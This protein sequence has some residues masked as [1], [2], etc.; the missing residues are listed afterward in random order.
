MRKPLGS[1]AWAIMA[2]LLILHN[3]FWLW[4]ESGRLLGMPVG[5]TY[6]VLYCLVTLMALAFL[7]RVAWPEPRQL[8]G[9]LDD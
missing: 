6:H 2:V 1:V 9:R 7:V 3:D 4:Q 8:D 5:L